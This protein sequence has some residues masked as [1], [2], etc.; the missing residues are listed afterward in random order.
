MRHLFQHTATISRSVVNGN[1]TTYSA[2]GSIA[3][4]IQP[5]SDA[6]AQGAMGRDSKDF[7]LFSTQEVRIGDRIVDQ[8]DKRY[9]VYGVK[10]HQFRSRSHY[11]ASLRS[12]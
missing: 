12:A 10:F 3:C 6:Y 9:E 2:V 4:N 11:E 1:K 5:V 7:R 8:N